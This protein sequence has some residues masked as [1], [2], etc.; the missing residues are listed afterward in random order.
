MI[1]F[2]RN[3]IIL[4]K[5]EWT[6]IISSHIF[7]CTTWCCQN[8]ESVRDSS[9]STFTPR[10]EGRCYPAA[11]AWLIFLGMWIFLKLVFSST[12]NNRLQDLYILEMCRRWEIWNKIR[13]RSCREGVQVTAPWWQIYSNIYK[14]SAQHLQHTPRVVRER[15]IHNLSSLPDEEIHH[16]HTHNTHTHT[17]DCVGP[18]IITLQSAGGVQSEVDQTTGVGNS[19]L[20][21]GRRVA[22]WLAPLIDHFG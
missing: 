5:R 2:L 16:T 22:D 15:L 13:R 4:S 9:L 10:N 17:H 11:A 19:R 8:H 3:S 21:G 14:R 1:N 20:Q 12:N 6:K 18:V 7:W